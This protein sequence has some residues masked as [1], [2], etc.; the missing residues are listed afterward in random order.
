LITDSA[1]APLSAITPLA[2]RIGEALYIS[3]INPGSGPVG[4]SIVIKGNAFTSVDSLKF[5]PSI[6]LSNNDFTILNDST[7]NAVVPVGTQ[8]GV[9]CA[10]ADTRTAC[11]PL[12]FTVLTAPAFCG[13]T[14]INSAIY[15][16]LTP[17][18]ALLSIGKREAYYFNAISGTSYVFNTCDTTL[19][20]TKIRL[21][22][23]AGTE[24]ASNDD[25]GPYCQ[26]I[27]A[28][29]YYTAATTGNVYVVVTSTDCNVLSGNT[30]LTYQSIAPAAAPII[31]S[32]TPA[33]GP[34]GT[35]VK[36]LGKHFTGVTGV[37]FNNVVASSIQFVS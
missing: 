35:T 26:G 9:I 8:T 31:T 23:V 18:V 24:I 27:K 22:D 34:V 19:V 16:I 20:N 2:Y 32:F 36:I 21:Y 14:N 12:P 4:V 11:S 6:K 5:F 30:T 3:S 15:P 37:A 33:S 7:I 1:C 13:T 28:S 25:N 17:R 29:L 10:I